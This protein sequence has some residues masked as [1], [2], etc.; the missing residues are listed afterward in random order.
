MVGLLGILIQLGLGVLSFSVLV[1]KRLRENPPRP[2]K[3]W[4]FDISKQ[5]VSQM[6]A[7]FINLTISIALTYSDSTSDECLW[8]FTTNILDNTIGVFICL[9]CLLSIEKKF[10]S[11]GKTQYVSG[12]YYSYQR[13]FVTIEVINKP[14]SQNN[15]T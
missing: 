10:I 6:M 15:K 7:H 13:V 9:C 4:L 8:Y 11:E 1:V 2:W 3:I 12:N 14:L 5:L